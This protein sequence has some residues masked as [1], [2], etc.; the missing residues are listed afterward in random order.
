MKYCYVHYTKYPS[1]IDRIDYFIY[2]L[3]YKLLFIY[4]LWVFP[5]IF[6]SLFV[7]AFLC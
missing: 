3:T 5:Y 6:F 4:I 1:Q 7:Y 2:N